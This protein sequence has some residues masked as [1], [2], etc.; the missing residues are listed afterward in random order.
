M[1]RVGCAGRSLLD[2]VEASLHGLSGRIVFTAGTRRSPF[3]AQMLSDVLGKSV[4]V[5]EVLEPSAVAGVMLSSGNEVAGSPHYPL[6]EPDLGRHEAYGD[7]YRD[8]FARL[9]EAHG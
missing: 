2:A 9:R 7:R 8:L 5:A 4:S 1:Q 6:Y 3:V